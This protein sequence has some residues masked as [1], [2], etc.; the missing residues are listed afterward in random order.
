M[1]R[2]VLAEGCSLA[3]TRIQYVA[4]LFPQACPE[5]PRCGSKSTNKPRRILRITATYLTLTVY[6]P[7]CSQ[8]SLM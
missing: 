6:S 3:Q 7:S 4:R 8:S 1:K 5:C 2:R